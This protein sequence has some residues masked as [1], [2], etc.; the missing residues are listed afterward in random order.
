MRLKTTHTYLHHFISVMALSPLLASASMLR[1]EN[2]DTLFQQQRQQQQAQQQQFDAKV[3]NV[4]LSD[5]VTKSR[6]QFPD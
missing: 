3:P 2:T 6:L 5:P 4:T 1:P